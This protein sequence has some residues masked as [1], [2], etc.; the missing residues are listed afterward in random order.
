MLLDGSLSTSKICDLGKSG[1]LQASIITAQGTPNRYSSPEQLAGGWCGPAAD[2]YSLGIVM[3]E[4]MTGHAARGRDARSELQLRCV[5]CCE[6]A[7]LRAHTRARVCVCVCMCV[8][9]CA[10][11]VAVACAIVVCLPACRVPEHCPLDVAQLVHACLSEDPTK[12]PSA[13]AVAEALGCGS[14]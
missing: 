11:V 4:V 13:A 12:R 7:G 3:L 10:A 9:V 6:V 2:L 14:R 8:C 5:C 1:I